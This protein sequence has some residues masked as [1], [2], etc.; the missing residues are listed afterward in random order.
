[1]VPGSSIFFVIFMSIVVFSGIAGY[2]TRNL[3]GIF[4]VQWVVFFLGCLLSGMERGLVYSYLS[5]EIIIVILGCWAFYNWGP[6]EMLATQ[7]FSVLV[8]FFLIGAMG[9]L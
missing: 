1:M 6:E 8:F 5:I 2:F 4:A 7:F 3:L 9:G